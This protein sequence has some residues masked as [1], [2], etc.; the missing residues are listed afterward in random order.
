MIVVFTLASPI[1]GAAQLTAGDVDDNL[2]LD[3]FGRWAQRTRENF[4]WLPSLDLA[5][6]VTVLVTDENGKPFANARVRV[7]VEGEPH[8]LIESSAGSDGVFRFFPSFDGADGAENFTLEAWSADD[9]ANTTSVALSLPALDYERTVSLVVP[10]VAAAPSA[11]DLMIVLDTTGSMQ[12][13][14]SYL[15]KELGTIV[16]QVTSDH[17]GLDIRYSLVVYRDTADEY[18]FKSLPFTDS[19]QNMRSYLAAQRASGGG[20]FPEA[21]EQG[22]REAANA[23]WRE[24]N[25]A[26]VAILS[27]DAPPHREN[28]GKALDEISN[29]RR[30]GVH[31]YAL[32]ASGVETTAEYILRA[33]A[34]LTQGRYM[35]LTDDSAVG[36]GHAEPHI[37]CYQV[38][39]LTELL[40]RV[41]GGEITGARIEAANGTVI[42]EVGNFSQGVCISA[43]EQSGPVTPALPASVYMEPAD[44]GPAPSPPPALVLTSTEPAPEGPAIDGSAPGPGAATIAADGAVVMLGSVRGSLDTYEGYSIWGTGPVHVEFVASYPNRTSVDAA[45]P[46]PTVLPAIDPSRKP[47]A[48]R[49]LSVSPTTPLE[50]LSMLAAPSPALFPPESAPLVLTGAALGLAMVMA[51]L[52]AEALRRQFERR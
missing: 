20:D 35:F 19:L 16:G 34:A 3:F 5:D 27:G 33:G 43:D 4:T 15:T 32:A 31:L 2:N 21:V 49:D 44:G 47:E 25:V 22:L 18:V 23:S 36:N 1:A 8:A 51:G 39:L 12:D 17:P 45:G 9:S 30:A 52:S 24:G 28:F 14:L 11:L 50:P 10:G 42:R 7:T 13:E 6:R 41:I 26:R 29:L 46:S 37:E 48:P 40:A 38:T